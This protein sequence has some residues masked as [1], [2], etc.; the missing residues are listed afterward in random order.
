M[1][2]V[3]QIVRPQHN[4]GQV[5][6]ESATDFPERRFA[7]GSTLFVERDGRVGAMTIIDARPHDARWV[8]GFEGVKS[9]EDAER[10]RGLELRVPAEAL[11][12]L[13]PGTFFIHDLV[14]CEVWTVAGMR[15]GSVTRVEAGSGAPLLVIASVGGEVLVPFADVFVRRV[16][17]AAHR[18]EIDP[19]AGLLDLNRPGGSRE[20]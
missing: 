10:L 15:V 2:T 13:A 5:V 16:D 17:L 4:R 19:P 8:V 6:V 11:A 18:I 1:I 12:E 7:P 9:I 3:G 20:T 14:G